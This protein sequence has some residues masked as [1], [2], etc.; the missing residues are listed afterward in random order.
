MLKIEN[1]TQAAADAQRAIDILTRLTAEDPADEDFKAQLDAAR[2][3]H[4]EMKA[5]QTA[6]AES[7]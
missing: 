1:P 2:A 5:A 7:N 3:L 6:P 4:A